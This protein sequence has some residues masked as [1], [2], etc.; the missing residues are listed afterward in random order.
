[1][2]VSATFGNSFPPRQLTAKMFS[3]RV[4]WPELGAV[5][6]PSAAAVA[7]AVDAAMDPPPSRGMSSSTRRAVEASAAA[8]TA[9]I[10]KPPGPPPSVVAGKGKRKEEAEGT[11]PDPATALARLL[12]ENAVLMKGLRTVGR[13]MLTLVCLSLAPAWCQRLKQI[14]SS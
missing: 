2:L 12:E 14:S 13:W 5:D 4:Q 6:G 7:V 3:P 1:V 10:P 11:C 9:A 8:A